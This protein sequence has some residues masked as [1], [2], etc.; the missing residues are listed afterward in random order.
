M[1]ARQKVFG[2][3]FQKTGTTSLGQALRLLGYKTIS[4]EDKKRCWQGLLNGIPLDELAYCLDP[5]DAFEDNPFF[6]PHIGEERRPFYEWAIVKYPDA[7]FILTSRASTEIW[8]KSLVG[9]LKRK[10]IYPGGAKPGTQ[11]FVKR[12]RV[13]G[14][15]AVSTMNLEL[16][17]EVYDNY[18]RD[19]RAYFTENAPDKFLDVCWEN[20][21]GWNDICPF[22]GCQKP[23]SNKFPHQRKAPFSLSFHK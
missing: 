19:A 2:I 13:Y 17:A 14:T 3:G 10:K 22:L 1:S 9:H 23:L 18:I 5:W 6:W 7:K 4:T 12:A 21:D 15:E 8:I 11:K 16:F 20:G